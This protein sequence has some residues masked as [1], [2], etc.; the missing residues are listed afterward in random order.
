MTDGGIDWVDPQLAAIKEKY[1]ELLGDSASALGSFLAQHGER[2]TPKELVT[3]TLRQAK[4]FTQDVVDFHADLGQ[5]LLNITR[6][7]VFESLSPSF[8]EEEAVIEEEEGADASHGQPKKDLAKALKEHV[9]KNDSGGRVVD[10]RSDTS[11]DAGSEMEPARMTPLEKQCCNAQNVSNSDVLVKLAF[12][13]YFATW[14]SDKEAR[15]IGFG[16]E[17]RSGE[18]A[19][20]HTKMK[21]PSFDSCRDFAALNEHFTTVAQV[22]ADNNENG[23]SQLVHGA[24]SESVSTFGAEFKPLQ[25]YWSHYLCKKFKGQGLPCNFDNNLA[26]RFKT[27]SSSEARK[28]TEAA[29]VELK[30]IRQ[31]VSA[32]AAANRKLSGEVQRIGTR[33]NPSAVKEETA[34]AKERIKGSKCYNCGKYGHLA[35]DCDED[36]KRVKEEDA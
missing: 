15:K 17:I 25:E 36:D 11:S 32:L 21:L 26:L 6:A 5:P 34:A 16:G 12:N 13:L 29:A 27:S 1:D 9:K 23:L 14:L 22:C 2:F 30:A 28:A 24:W 7:D 3:L 33:A 19:R 20:A 31:E 18:T 8:V 35:K 10:L 4:A